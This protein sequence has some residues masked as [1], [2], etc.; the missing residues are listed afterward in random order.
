M[1]EPIE[2]IGLRISPKC[3][4]AGL[5]CGLLPRLFGEALAA[6]AGGASAQEVGPAVLTLARAMCLAR[7]LVVAASLLQFDVFSSD[8]LMAQL[9]AAV[10]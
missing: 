5:A 7:L 3:K 9:C 8:K 2:E 6:P 4:E 1:R 10:P